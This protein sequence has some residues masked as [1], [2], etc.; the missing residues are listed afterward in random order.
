M[1]FAVL[2]KRLMIHGF[3]SPNYPRIKL[4]NRIIEEDLNTVI[5][6]LCDAGSISSSA[7]ELS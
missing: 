5:A 4:D 3:F 6:R 1:D 7:T 2:D